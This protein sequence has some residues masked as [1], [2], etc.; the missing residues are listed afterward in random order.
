[1]GRLAAIHEGVPVVLH[2]FHGHVFHSYFGKAKT[3]LFIEIERYLAARS[4]GIIAIS[5]EQKRELAE[6]YRIAPAERIHVVPLGF[7]LDRFR[8]DREAKRA[9]FRR[10]YGLAEQ[11]VAVG[12]VGRLVPV[13]NHG[14]FLEAFRQVWTH[15]QARQAK[16]C[17]QPS[18]RESL[19]EARGLVPDPRDTAR[20]APRLVA[21][22]IGDGESR[23]DIEDACRR[24]DLPFD[25][26]HDEEGRMP[27]R[28]A[29]VVFTSWI[30]DV[31]RAFAG[32]DV[33]AL[34]S[35]NEGTPV[36]LIEALAA[37]KPCVSTDVG[38]VRDVLPQEHYKFL[39]PSQSSQQFSSALEGLVF[40]KRTREHAGRSGEISVYNSYGYERLIFDTR[41]IY[42]LEL[43]KRSM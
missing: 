16:E 33:V 14:L 26:A 34:S 7:D 28:Q 31:D 42:K 30:K 13:K 10:Q 8:T 23:G 27:A 32:L 37:G 12:I 11:D 21:F 36:S 22:L 3:R 17:V 4:S 6:V 41:Q 40:S 39:V 5:P 29:A 20:D 25:A 2:T 1:V 18:F 19:A 38:G 24:L 43:A 35:R 15:W 9:A